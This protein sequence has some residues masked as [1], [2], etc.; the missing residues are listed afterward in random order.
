MVGVIAEHVKAHRHQL[1]KHSLFVGSAV[2]VPPED[3]SV[4]DVIHQLALAHAG[5]RLGDMEGEDRPA[6]ALELAAAEIPDHATR[7]RLFREHQGAES[8]P[9]EGHVRLAR[10]IKDG[11]Y[12]TIFL[13]EPDDMLE[14]AL[15]AQ[16]MEP[17]KD[18]HLLVAGVDEPNDIRVALAESTRIAI[19][20]CGGSLE[21]GF[22]PLSPGEVGQIAAA[23]EGVI[24]D[25]FK[26]FSVFVAMTDREDPFLMRV[27]REG[28]KIFWINMMIPMANAELYDELKIESPASAEYH[29]LQPHVMAL[30]DARHSSRHLLCREPGSFN[31]FFA[32][33]HGRLIRHRGRRRGQRTDLT[34]LRGGPYRFLDYFDTEDEDFYFG[35]EQDVEAVMAKIQDHP[36]TVVFGRIAVGKT[37]LLRAGIMA[38]LRRETEEAD[39]EEVK[40]WLVGYSRVGEDPVASLRAA[41]LAAA[42]EAGYDPSPPGEDETLAE[43]VTRISTL[44]ERKVIILLDQFAEFFVKL[45]EKVRERFREAVKECLE[46]APEHFRLVIT[47]RE[48]Y[49]GEVYEL[50]SDFPAI[51]HNVH[52]LHKLTREQAEDAIL[53]PAQN[54]ELQVERGLV[55]RIVDDLYREGVEPAQLQ[56]VCHSLYEARPP[57][58]RVISERT[59]EQLGGAEV[60]LD[61]YLERS[62]SRL[63][64]GE[65]RT[66]GKVLSF[67]TSGSE[68]RAAQPLDRVVAEVQADKEALE[69]VLAHLVDVGLVRPVGKG[70]AREYELV[71][72]VLAEKVTASVAGGV[73][74]IRDLQ[75]LLTRAM[76]DFTQFGLLVNAEE[77]KLINNA[78]ED[79]AIGPEQLRLI[80]RSALSADID[81]QYWLDRVDELG[82]DKSDFIAAMMRDE[83]VEVRQRTYRQ[84]ADHLEPRL[85]RHLVNGLTDEDADVRTQ[86][87]QYLGQLEPHLLGMLENNDLRV[88][89][90]AARAIAH[91]RARRAVRPLVE[92][93]GEKDPALRDEIT[94]ALL[95]IDDPKA[96]DMLLRAIISGSGQMWD[97]AHA[98]GRLSVGEKELKSLRRAASGRDRWQLRYALGVALTYRR[99]FTEAAEVLGALIEALPAEST[100]ALA[101]KEALEDLEEQRRRASAG[102][103]AWVMFARTPA[104]C[105]FTDQ[106][107]APPLELA[108]QFET[109]DHVIASP[110]VRDHTA[111]IGSRDRHLY[112]IDTG[113]GTARW[114][115]EAADRI[116]GAAAISH[117]M[118]CVGTLNGTVHA[119]EISSGEQRWRAALGSAIRAG[120]TVEGDALYLGTRG[121]LLACLEMAT[122]EVV[123]RREARGEISTAVAVANQIAVAGCW[124]G[125]ITALDATT[126]EEMWRYKTQAPVSSS[127]AIDSDVIYCGS[128]DHGLY[129]LDL[130][131]G[132]LVWRRDLGGQVRSSPA[133]S[134]D[135]VVVGSIDTHC[136]GVRRDNG[137]IVWS[138]PT[139]E[140]IMASPAISAGHVYIGSKDGALYALDLATGEIT[141]RHR[142][143]F[144]VYSSPAVAEQTVYVGFNYYN[145]AAFRPAIKGTKRS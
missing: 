71:H 29:R 93:F 31:E 130:R 3:K 110:V 87:G 38:S 47:I 11:Y 90:L 22:L 95:A 23:I 113:K 68:L 33:L 106:E 72:E 67:L 96:P 24:S 102:E 66:A 79:L 99:A 138:T 121:G 116:E 75:D 80:V 88:R 114:S 76:N 125:H 30:L 57:S 91:T 141:W 28:G 7:C 35:R 20:K 85:I 84:L 45:G 18:Y 137:E 25:A 109:K 13:A 82:Q 54:F 12:S 108:W 51:L 50:Q 142:S 94:A 56:I 44:T 34:V 81:V 97:V 10:L 107:V 129:A 53:K 135:L 16:H 37:S 2:R 63:P 60:I 15:R 42:Q 124:D 27:P 26:I 49:L 117:E 119:L 65:R 32:K 127:P 145:L 128:D 132:E 8:R 120:C 92:A 5:D 112:A 131:S 74:M 64:A 36:L 118:V 43:T 89:A 40:P 111:Y 17:E 1:G 98:L 100:G 140:E 46:Q 70:R 4:M 133:L 136:Y 41:M 105:S 78:R 86:A 48:D 58:S 123:W 21:H 134:A 55:H 143:P 61:K 83:N 73:A 19:V 62:L 144:G 126:G 14:R 59:Y 139:S 39:K 103:D 9:A 122:G 77:L 52:R 115:F 101:A 69:R 6:A 104:H